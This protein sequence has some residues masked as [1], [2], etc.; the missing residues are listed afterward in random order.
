MKRSL[1]DL[2]ALNDSSSYVSSDL[3]EAYGAFSV[4]AS[5]EDLSE[6]FYLENDLIKVEVAA[7]GARVTSVYLKEYQTH[8]SFH[9]TYFVKTLRV[10]ISLFGRKIVVYKLLILFL[11]PLKLN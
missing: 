2:S 6:K 1:S 8:D 4:A 9:L 11:M 3:K 10:L 7:K 5:K